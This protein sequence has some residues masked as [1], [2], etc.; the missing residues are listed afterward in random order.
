MLVDHGKKDS[1]S[2][3]RAMRDK[4][5]YK[6]LSVG[7]G[8]ERSTAPPLLREFAC[9][10]NRTFVEKTL[11]NFGP[12]REIQG[13]NLRNGKEGESAVGGFFSPETTHAKYY[14]RHD[15]D[16]RGRSYK[17][18]NPMHV[19]LKSKI[20]EISASKRTFKLHDKG[21][22]DRFRGESCKPPDVAGVV[23]DP[24]VFTFDFRSANDRTFQRD[25]ARRSEYPKTCNPAKRGA[26]Q[27]M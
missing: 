16:G 12:D 5:D 13:I 6:A 21:Q 4:A 24:K 11:A 18:A 7:P 20:G 2:T 14:R 10:H 15:K 19:D 26:E 23:P 22:A 8:Y 25:F 27:E 17:P 1:M 3:G 9:T